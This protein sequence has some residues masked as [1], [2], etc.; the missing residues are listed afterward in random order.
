MKQQRRWLRNGLERLVGVRSF[1]GGGCDKGFD[2][3]RI[4]GKLSRRDTGEVLWIW[5]G[6]KCARLLAARNVRAI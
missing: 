5:P 1:E 2:E 6:K 3:R 4:R